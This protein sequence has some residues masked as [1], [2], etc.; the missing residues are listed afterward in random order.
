[1]WGRAQRV[2]L[3]FVSCS[4]GCG[5][6]ST[7]PDA[8]PDATVTD[9]PGDT[10]LE[11]S[12][13]DAADGGADVVAADA[14]ATDAGADVISMD[15]PLEASCATLGTGCFTCCAAEDPDAAASLLQRAY[16]CACGTVSLC[17][18][19]CGMSLC[20]SAQ[21]DPNCFKCITAHPDAGNCISSAE[22]AACGDADVG[23]LTVATCWESCP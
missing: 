10:K 16:G 7:P 3:G 11:G 23:C 9:A 17:A 18:T 12:A 4:L 15:A 22:P 13:V 20:K 14:D 8:G 21:P 6:D 5:G 1:M 2:A 19:P